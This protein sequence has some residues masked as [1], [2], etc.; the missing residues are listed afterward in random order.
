MRITLSHPLTHPWKKTPCFFC[1]NGHRVFFHLFP[2]VFRTQTGIVSGCFSHRFPLFFDRRR[3]K[4]VFCRDTTPKASW[5]CSSKTHTGKYDGDF[6]SQRRRL[7]LVLRF[8]KKTFW[9]K[10]FKN[11]PPK[12]RRGRGVVKNIGKRDDVPQGTVNPSSKTHTGK[13]D[14]NSA[15]QRRRFILVLR[16]IKKTFWVKNF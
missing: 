5:K 2:L 11:G 15:S 9:I 4:K 16:F 10:H 1:T 8:I 14:G 7:T 12:P 6:A 3:K 13:Y